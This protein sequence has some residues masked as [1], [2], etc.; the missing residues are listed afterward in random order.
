MEREKI[1]KGME[2]K[3]EREKIKKGMERKRESGSE[4][5]KKSEMRKVERRNRNTV[6]E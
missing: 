1:E 3:R 6:K 2:R 5:N 4:E